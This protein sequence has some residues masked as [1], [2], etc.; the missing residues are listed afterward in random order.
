MA[1]KAEK[2]AT[3]VAQSVIDAFNRSDWDSLRSRVAANMV[4]QETGTGRRIQGVDAYIELCQGWKQ[5]FADVTGT[6]HNTV[7][8]G[9]MVAQEV[10]WEGTHTGPLVGPGGTLAPTGRRAP[11]PATMW[12]MIEGDRVREIHH[13]L[14]F[15]TLL[16]ALGALPAPAHA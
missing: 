6:V 10:T 7:A 1:Q 11:V 9:D 4:Y 16:Q 12:Y 14:D 5:T 2:D 13:H 15:M 8:S 3:R